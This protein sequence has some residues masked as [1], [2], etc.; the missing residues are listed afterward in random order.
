MCSEVGVLQPP[1]RIWVGAGSGPAR[2][3]V[4]LLELAVESMACSGDHGGSGVS[5]RSTAAIDS[6][7]R[8]RS[9]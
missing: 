1:W 7:W 5:G 2:R 9:P 4:L 6:L 3:G 8:Q